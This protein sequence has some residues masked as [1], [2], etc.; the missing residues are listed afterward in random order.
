MR[1]P[2]AGQGD[3]GSGDEIANSTVLYYLTCAL[4]TGMQLKNMAAVA[5]SICGS[6]FVPT[7]FFCMRCS[8]SVRKTRKHRAGRRDEV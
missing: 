7:K 2:T 4:K 5:D 3:A 6:C 8:V 1:F